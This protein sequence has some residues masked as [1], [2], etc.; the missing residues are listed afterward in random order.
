MGYER[1][2]ERETSELLIVC[3]SLHQ[4][5]FI[6]FKL[7]KNKKRE[8]TIAIAQLT[9]NLIPSFHHV[10]LTQRQT[11][12]QF[13][14]MAVSRKKKKVYYKR[15]GKRRKTAPNWFEKKKKL[16]LFLQVRLCFLFYFGTSQ[17]YCYYYKYQKL[18]VPLTTVD[19]CLMLYEQTTD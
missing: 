19:C 3:F 6:Y 4:P 10:I 8:R 1:E 16:Q 12:I 11:Q 7:K 5:S 17:R 14:S 9:Y 15:S 13:N 2:R 18:R